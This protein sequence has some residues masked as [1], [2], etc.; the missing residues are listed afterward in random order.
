MKYNQGINKINWEQLTE[1][2]GEIGLVAGYGKKK[3]LIKI[4]KAFKSSFKVI[5]AWDKNKLVGAGRLVS[6]GACYGMIFDIGVLPEY[7]KKGIGRKIV[8]RLLEENQNLCIHLT[9][10]FGNEKF[11]NKLG[12]CSHKTAM[13]KYPYKS[14][15][16]IYE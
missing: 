4:K 1:L 16:L 3:D 5:T 9:S 15:Y 10:T 13:A 8:L 14:D 12:F 11:Y 7:Q 6:D 2:Y